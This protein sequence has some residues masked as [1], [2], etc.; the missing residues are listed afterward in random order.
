M[1]S[2]R[3]GGTG[4]RLTAG[5]LGFAPWD[6]SFVANPY[7]VYASLREAHPVLYDD[8]TDHWLVSRHEDVNALLVEVKR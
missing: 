1:A 7:P 3:A 5:E 4:Q 2:N 6:G 8:S